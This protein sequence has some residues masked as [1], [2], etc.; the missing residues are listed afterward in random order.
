VD[1][2]GVFT[3]G[4]PPVEPVFE[5]IKGHD[6]ARFVLRPRARRL[7]RREVETEPE[8]RSGRDETQTHESLSL[9]D[10]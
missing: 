3:D 4:L 8:Q 7:R 2:D 5:I 6:A 9:P 10:A 1:R